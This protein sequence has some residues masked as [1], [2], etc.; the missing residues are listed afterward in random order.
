MRRVSKHSLDFCE[1]RRA[2]DVEISGIIVDFEIR[3]AEIVGNKLID[4]VD[5]SPVTVHDGDQR[6]LCGRIGRIMILKQ[7][8]LPDESSDA[9]IEQTAVERFREKCVRTYLYP[10][11]MGFLPY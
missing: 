11:E 7:M 9:R 3:V 4:P 5:E 10:A 8:P 1:Q 6:H 2:S